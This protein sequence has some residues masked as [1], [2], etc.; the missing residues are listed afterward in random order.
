[1]HVKRRTIFIIFWALLLYMSAALV[2]WFLLLNKQNTTITQGSYE[3]LQTSTDSTANPIAYSLSKK[4]IEHQYATKQLTYIC[5]ALAFFILIVIGAVLIYKMVLKQFK[6]ATQQHNF[7]MAVTHEL[8]TPIAVAQLNLQTINKHKN[9]PEATKQQLINNT[10]TETQR[11]DQLAS[12]ILLT[13]KLDGGAYQMEKDELA[14]E[15]LILESV[16]T[17]KQ[18]FGSYHFNFIKKENCTLL[19]DKFLMQILINNL[20]SNAVKY[21]AAGNTITVTVDSNWFSIADEG[22]GIIDEDKAKVFKKFMRLGKENIRQTK[23]TGI[24]LYLCHKII[25]DSNGTITIKDNQPKGTI[26]TVQFKQTYNG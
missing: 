24:G 18:N 17:Y 10:L 7:M 13:S 26:F 15:E 12:N 22:V 6:M 1:M 11:L 2:W 5:E 4:K 16:N 3:I 19:A 9:L 8:K 23:G 14:F 21:S 25:T 20:L